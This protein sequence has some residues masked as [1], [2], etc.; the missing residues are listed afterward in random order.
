MPKEVRGELYGYGLAPTDHLLDA[1]V[2]AKGVLW[3]R[4]GPK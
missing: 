3:L 4:T 2:K 1:T